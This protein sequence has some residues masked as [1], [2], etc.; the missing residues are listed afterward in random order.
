EGDPAQSTTQYDYDG[1]RSLTA[2]REGLESAPRLTI[3]VYDAYDRRVQ[4]T[5]PMG[6]ETLYHYDANGNVGGDR[7]PG[8][9]NPFG[10]QVLGE[11]VDGPLGLFN[12]RLRETNYVYDA[13]DRRVL[14]MQRH[15]NGATQ[16][17][18]GDGASTT[19]T[20]W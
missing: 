5:D 12:V 8:V 20:V 3:Y 6:N 4:V 18:I 19:T 2:L 15:F 9:P 1:H 10:E 13:L 7:T 11:L 14:A 17:P 16:A